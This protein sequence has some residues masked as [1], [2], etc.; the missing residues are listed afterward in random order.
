MKSLM[1]LGL[2]FYLTSCMHLGMMGTHGDSQSSEHQMAS[3]TTLE[4]EVIADNV[5]A[6][7]TFPPLALNKEIV[8]ELQLREKESGRPIS[9]AKVSFHAAFLHKA[10]GTAEHDADMMHGAVDPSHARSS[11]DHAT[12]FEQDIHES[13][14]PGIYSVSFTPLQSGEHT[15]MFHVSAIENETLEQEFV[16]EA[17]RNAASGETSHGGMMHG[18]N[19]TS[20][21]LMIGGV[22]MGAMMIVMWTTRGSIF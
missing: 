15:F 17:T 5:V 11:I 1:V 20:E 19:S 4:K 14:H 22:L 13:S 6:L 16:I 21:Y 12:N 2:S 10:E 9:D 3:R 18:M 8:F 7:A